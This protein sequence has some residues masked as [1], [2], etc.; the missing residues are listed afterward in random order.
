MHLVLTLPGLR[1]QAAGRDAHA[2]H[3]ARLMACAGKP[4]HDADG[5]DAMLAA[6]YGIAHAAGTDCPLAAVRLAALGVDPAAAFWL[7]ADPVTLVAGRDDVRLVGAVHDLA[8]NDAA[9]LTAMLNAHFASDGVVFVAPRPDA[10]FVRAAAPPALRTRPVAMVTGRMLRD[11]LP[12]GSDAGTW[13]RWQN[14][15][16][17]LL[18]E[19][20][21]NAARAIDGKAPVNG[22][23]FCEGGLSPPRGGKPTSIRTFADGGIACALARHAGRAAHNLPESLDA[24]LASA[25]D[26]AVT[27]V[28]LDAPLDLVRVDRA[29]AAPGWVALAKGR[30][31]AVTL[32]TDDADGA[33]AWTAQRPGPAQ[34]IALRFTRHDLASLVAAREDA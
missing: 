11:L 8:A 13:R 30:L 10:W 18:H 20:P 1:A 28:S 17:M 4:V 27:V 22:I 14:E 25:G 16:Q 2:P 33:V 7:A 15:I 19:H 31:G 6:Q 32:L 24:V 3:L 21:V 5:L 26:A 9:T 23:W 34:R 12:T 29:W